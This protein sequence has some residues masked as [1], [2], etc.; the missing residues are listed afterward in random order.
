ML[1][2]VGLMLT[3]L[4]SDYYSSPAF[5]QSGPTTITAT[6]VLTGPVDD[7]NQDP[8][9]EFRLTDEET[10]RTLNLIS[11]FVDLE[12]YAGQRVTIEV[13]RMPGIDPNAYNATQSPSRATAVRTTTTVAPAIAAP[14]AAGKAPY[15]TPVA[16]S[17]SRASRVPCS[18]VAAC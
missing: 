13:V 3:T 8:T 12:A 11:G 16:P 10:G 14:V 1:A 5:A 9:P 4:L 17:R 18:S 6:V 15:L 2:L 7:G